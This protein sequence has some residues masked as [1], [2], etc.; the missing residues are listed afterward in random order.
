MC[1]DAKETASD[2][3]ALQNIHEH[4]IKFMED[5]EAQSGVSFIVL[6]YTKRDEIFYIPFRDIKTFWDRAQG[7]GRKSFCYDEVDKGFRITQS[8]GVV[9]HYLAAL[10]QDLEVRG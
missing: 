8:E 4:Q 1:F 2:T 3:Y 9:V 6:H 10:K 5:F 7:G